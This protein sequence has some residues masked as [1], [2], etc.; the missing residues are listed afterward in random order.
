MKFFRPRW[1][2][3]FADLWSNKIRSLLVV[4]SITIGVFAAG[5]ILSMNGIISPDMRASYQNTNPANIVISAPDFD[6]KFADTIKHMPQVADAQ[7]MRTFVIR[8]HVP[9]ETPG[10]AD[11]WIN[12]TIKAVPD[13]K[14][15]TTNQVSLIEGAWPP[16]DKEIVF[17]QH[18][19][20]DARTPLGGLVELKL[21]DGKLLRQVPLVGLVRDESIGATGGGGYFTSNLTGYVNFN[22]LEWLQQP[23]QANM[24]LVR[25]KDNSNDNSHLFDVASLISKKFDDNNLPL[26]NFFVRASNNHPNAT[27]IEAVSGILFILGFLVVFLSGFLIT[28]T[29]SALLNQQIEQIG[30][31]KTLGGRSRQIISIYMILIL[32]YSLIALAI[33]LPLSGQVAYWMLNFLANEVNFTL[34]GYREVPLS[35]VVQTLIALLIPQLAG[36]LPILRGSMIS[37]QEAVNGATLNKV[38]NNRSWVNRLSENIRG[39]SRPLLIS[40]R[41][42][43]RRKTRLLL[44]L[45]TLTLGGAIFIATFNV[46]ASMNSFIVKLGN[47]FSADITLDF[48]QP[49]HTQKIESMLQQQPN[50]SDVEGWGGARAELLLAG[51]KPAANSS[52]PLCSKAAGWSPGM[53][54]HWRSTIISKAAFPT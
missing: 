46:Q 9:P 44:T 38:K 17:D 35:I 43:F 28:N 24:L 5:I 4:A 1:K 15:M 10:A 2:K 50:I 23:E 41:N 51:D 30:I 12:I 22:T 42:T 52:N 34:Q 13:F 14:K 27:Y 20:I 6:Q 31:I 36:F 25:V 37:V 45:I 11:S 29:L 26:N 47:Y 19:F 54:M 16:K 40:L 21:P 49:Y 33:A 3:V 53:K 32:V 48:S 7:A 39:L 8:M 18:K